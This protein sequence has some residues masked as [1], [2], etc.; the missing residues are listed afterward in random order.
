MV[1]IGPYTSSE[2]IGVHVL[3]WGQRHSPP[4]GGG[5]LLKTC[6]SP[7][8]TTCVRPRCPRSLANQ[9]GY[10]YKWNEILLALSLCALRSGSWM[11]DTSMCIVPTKILLDRGLS[12][13][14]VLDRGL[15][16]VAWAAY[17][18]NGALWTCLRPTRD[19]ANLHPC[20][21]AA[22]FLQCTRQ[23]GVVAVSTSTDLVSVWTTAAATVPQ[24]EPL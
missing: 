2:K 16:H 23:S 6:V 17:W 1:V 5:T 10:H 14:G 11:L 22:Y 19:S 8:Q 13:T 12:Q 4:F 3:I 9:G 18:L 24:L 20:R 21:Q 7:D 15:S